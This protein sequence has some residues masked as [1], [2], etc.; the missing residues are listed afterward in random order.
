[1]QVP[2]VVNLGQTSAD[3]QTVIRLSFQLCA[4]FVARGF[5]TGLPGGALP[6]NDGTPI[7][8]LRM[9]RILD[10]DPIDV[11]TALLRVNRI[12]IFATKQLLRCSS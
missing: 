1:M 11:L 6:V 9:R 3:V 8:V 2:K 4:P 10:V 7:V 12:D 5:G